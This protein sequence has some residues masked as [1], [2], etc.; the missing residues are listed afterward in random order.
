MKL[1]A[2]LM[3]VASSALGDAPVVKMVETTAL[4]KGGWRFDVTLS[5]PDTG[6]DHYADGW[7]VEDATGH[8]LG[9]RVLA[10]PHETEQPFT[11]SL[12]LDGPLPSIIYIRARCNV[13]GWSEEVFEVTLE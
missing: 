2:V 8:Q 6:W 1:A 3:F 13:D 12:S 4:A 9:L 5:H 7:S 11:R 10:H